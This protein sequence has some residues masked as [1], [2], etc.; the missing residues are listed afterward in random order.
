MGVGNMVK[1]KTIELFIKQDM[2]WSVYAIYGGLTYLMINYPTYK[3]AK[4]GLHYL[5]SLSTK[6]ILRDYRL[7]SIKTLNSLRDTLVNQGYKL[8]IRTISPIEW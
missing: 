3:Q 1:T 4:D 7:H 2:F 8:A 5:N 6:D